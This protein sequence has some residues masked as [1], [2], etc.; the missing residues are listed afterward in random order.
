MDFGSSLAHRSA[1]ST[2]FTINVIKDGKT[3]GTGRD[4]DDALCTT[5]RKWHN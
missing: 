3:S 4:T 1:D 2:T 5:P